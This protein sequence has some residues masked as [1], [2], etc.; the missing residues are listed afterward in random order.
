M[1]RLLIL[2]GSTDGQTAKIARF[3]ADEFHGKGAAVDVLLAGEVDPDPRDYDGVLV[4]ASVHAGGYQKAVVRWVRGHLD[5]LRAKPAGFLSVCLGVLQR[6]LAAHRQLGLIVNRF[7]A[8][9]GW[10]PPQVKVV[11]GALPYTRYS[12]LKRMVMK[13][14]V[15]KAGG[16]TDV[17]RDYEYTDWADLRGFAATF[18]SRFVS[19]EGPVD[20]C[21]AACSCSVPD[22]VA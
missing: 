11:A 8:R 19:H 4:A 2:Y 14:I 9:T 16:D 17:S 13:R 3:L 5:A 15:R 10:K 6:D 20:A 18:L 7:E 22:K 1:P 12:W 21:G